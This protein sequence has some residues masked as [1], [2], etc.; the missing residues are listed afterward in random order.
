V[1]SLCSS[2]SPSEVPTAQCEAVGLAGTLI[3]VSTGDGPD[4]LRL[5]ESKSPSVTPVL[6]VIL[7]KRFPFGGLLSR[8]PSG[9][10]STS[11]SDILSQFAQSF[12]REPP[13]SQGDVDLAQ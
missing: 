2:D 6:P 11:P 13:V 9:K 7:S 10:P 4:L 1:T 8:Q 3:Q 12:P 5:M